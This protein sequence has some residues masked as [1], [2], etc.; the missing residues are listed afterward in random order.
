MRCNRSR[1]LVLAA[2]LAAACT[3]PAVARGDAVTDW[4][5]NAN[6]AIF[7]TTGTAHGAAINTAMV[8]AAV[9]DA[10][11]AIAGRYRPYLATPRADP[12]ASQDAAVAT[13]AFRVAAAVAPSQLADLRSKY[14][15]S[16]SAL[17]AGPAKADGM[18]VGEAAA[19]AL[20]KARENDGRNSPFAFVYGTTPG[21][22]RKS[23]PLFALDPA[24]WAGNV[25]PFLLGDAAL[26]RTHGPNALTSRSYARDYNEV[27][28]L[29]SLTSSTRTP[30]QTRAA[31]FWQS[32]PG[33]LYGGVMR[34]LSV[35]FGLTTAENARLFAMASLAAADAAIACWNDK[36]HW[37][38]WRP[39]DAIRD[40]APD[41]NAGTQPDPSWTPLY[42]AATVTVPALSTP[43]FPDHPSGHSCVSSATL[44]VL[45]DFFGT[46]RI[47]FDIVSS[48]FP[49]QPRHFESFSQA[50]QEVVDARVWGGIHFREADVQGAEIGTKIARWERQHYFQKLGGDDA[51]RQ[52]D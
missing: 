12:M 34:S 18:A 49:T 37:N 31:I 39:I 45:R 2:A 48:R 50:L 16:L 43:S 19:A 32:Q 10:V 6:A 41:G 35:R 1:A 13:A 38:F 3:S 28:A 46:D 22:W 15:A 11:N 21:G 42:D 44:G 8:Q 51:G 30:D 14:E 24:P 9:Y 36:Y 27:K 20:L 7:A 17:P 40:P 47:G 33:G 4:N 29:G 52:A 5:T 23:P 26:L 25:T